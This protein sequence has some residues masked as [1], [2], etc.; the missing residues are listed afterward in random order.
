MISLNSMPLSN[1]LYMILP[2]A[3]LGELVQSE[4]VKPKPYSSSRRPFRGSGSPSFPDLKKKKSDAQKPPSHTM[5]TRTD[6][7]NGS[8]QPISFGG[9][10]TPSSSEH[11]H[12]TGA[13]ASTS[14]AT[15]TRSN[16]ASQ[17][18]KPTFSGRS[19]GTYNTETS[20]GQSTLR[21]KTPSSRTDSEGDYRVSCVRLP[22]SNGHTSPFIPF[23][24]ASGVGQE[25]FLVNGST[26]A[27]QMSPA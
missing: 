23:N 19:S 16:S 8:S 18:L 26:R 20:A 14:S 11:H 6:S 1:L 27:D 13:H 3:T 12:H 7:R 9:G 10:Q 5:R 17:Q 25:G 21:A 24:R 2:A 22:C 15:K 4:K